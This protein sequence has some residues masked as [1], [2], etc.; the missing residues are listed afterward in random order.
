MSVVN[1][2]NR[3]YGYF[4]YSRTQ[5]KMREEVEEKLGKKFIPGQ[6]LVNGKWKYFTQISK[7]SESTMYGDSVLITKGYLDEIKYTNCTNKWKVQ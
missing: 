7:T 3:E 2:K 1:D 5:H 6:V 4:L